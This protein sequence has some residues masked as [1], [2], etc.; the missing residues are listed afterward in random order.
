M[1]YASSLQFAWFAI[2]LIGLSAAFSLRICCGSRIE[3]AL[4][5][6]Y[7]VALAGVAVAALAGRHFCW[8]LGAWSAAAL[9]VMIVAAV[10]DG[11]A[12]HHA[13]AAPVRS[14]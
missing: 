11:G 7:L 13:H 4:Q 12:R 8:P 6:V 3:G 1:D 2:H 14:M 10:A 5:A 9:A